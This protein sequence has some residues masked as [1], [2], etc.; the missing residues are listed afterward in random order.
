LDGITAD[1]FETFFSEDMAQAWAEVESLRAQITDM[2][3]AQAET[4]T[5]GASEAPPNP[6]ENF[7]DWLHTLAIRR[8]SPEPS[9]QGVEA[10][11]D[12]AGIAF[13]A[14]QEWEYKLLE[15]HE[16][17]ASAAAQLARR[18]FSLRASTASDIGNRI[19]YAA[20]P[21]GSAER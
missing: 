2:A 3:I 7:G 14:A 19:M 16:D 20:A 21:T 5:A 17:D 10:M 4:G 13:K 6:T 12:A 1:D 11:R 8:P 18:D 9:R 15:I